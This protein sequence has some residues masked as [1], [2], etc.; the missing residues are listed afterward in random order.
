MMAR[1]PKNWTCE[2]DI[3]YWFINPDSGRWNQLQACDEK[4]GYITGASTLMSS[5]RTKIVTRA[6]PTTPFVEFSLPPSM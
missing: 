3:T 2:V 6:T 1:V 4:W 5:F